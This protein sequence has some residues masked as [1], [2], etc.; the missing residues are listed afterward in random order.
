MD[1]SLSLSAKDVVEKA[2]GAALEARVRAIDPM[3]T[4][5]LADDADLTVREW[6]EVTALERRILADRAI[7]LVR[8][9]LREGSIGHPRERVYPKVAGGFDPKRL[10]Q[11][12]EVQHGR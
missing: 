12:N 11:A 10:A 6:R 4:P 5:L 8:D 1:A 2:I 3:R 9:Q 7:N